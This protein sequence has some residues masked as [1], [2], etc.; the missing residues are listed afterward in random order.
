MN[1]GSYVQIQFRALEVFLTVVE[2]NSFTK[3]AETLY[4][5]QPAL[6]KTVQKLEEELNV[7]LFDR[8]SKKL[9]L[10]DEGKVLYQKSKDIIQK[11]NSIPDSLNEVSDVISGEVRVG[12]PQIIGTVFFP[13][14]AYTFLQKFPKVTLLTEESGGVIIEKLVNKGELDIGLVVLPVSKNTLQSELFYQDEFVV[15][16]SEEHP[17]ANLKEIYLGDLKDDHPAQRGVGRKIYPI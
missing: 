8:S 10:T 9:Q 2:K 17:M 5:G 6:S 12:I 11:V 14:I 15:C 1:G 7:K 16:I 13:K 3:A 4:V